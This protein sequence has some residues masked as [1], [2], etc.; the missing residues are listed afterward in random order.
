M[1]VILLVIYGRQFGLNIDGGKLPVSFESILM[2]NN[3]YT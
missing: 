3:M 2:H 1:T